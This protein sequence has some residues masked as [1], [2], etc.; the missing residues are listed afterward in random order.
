M[1]WELLAF[2]LVIVV[3]V[4][5]IREEGSFFSALW[6]LGAG[7]INPSRAHPSPSGGVDALDLDHQVQLG[8]LID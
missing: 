1:G 7:I 2:E 4:A 5:A 8:R 3:A 6:R